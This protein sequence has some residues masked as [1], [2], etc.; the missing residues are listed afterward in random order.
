METTVVKYAIFD[1]DNSHEYDVSVLTKKN[2]VK[3]FNLYYSGN[4]EWTNPNTLAM[5]I[6]DTG[7]G[8]K[9]DKSFRKINYMELAMLRILLT[10]ENK[11]DDNLHN[12]EPY[13]AI[14]IDE[15]SGIKL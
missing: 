9:F 14:L 10:I 6:T 13:R 1:S 2:G 11:T 12:R 3:T 15:K 5:S 8:I 7:D 4:T